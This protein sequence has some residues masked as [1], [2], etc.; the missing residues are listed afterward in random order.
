MFGSGLTCS[1]GPQKASKQPNREAS[2][3]FCLRQSRC[4]IGRAVTIME[5]RSIYIAQNLNMYNIEIRH[6]VF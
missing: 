6:F 2:G 5:F 3:Q 4:Q 1:Y